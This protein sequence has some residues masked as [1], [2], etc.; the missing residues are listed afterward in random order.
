MK[1]WQKVWVLTIGWQYD[2]GDDG[3]SVTLYHDRQQ[4]LAEMD[5]Q[6]QEEIKA[7]GEVYDITNLDDPSEHEGDWVLNRGNDSASIYEEGHYAFNH[8]TFKVEK[9]EIEPYQEHHTTNYHVEFKVNG[10]THTRTLLACLGCVE[11]RIKTALKELFDDY[12][13]VSIKE[14]K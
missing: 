14:I 10:Q 3:I 13:I 2:C 11:E 4:A 5:K 8:V 7:K 6:V 12:E 9:I 1:Q